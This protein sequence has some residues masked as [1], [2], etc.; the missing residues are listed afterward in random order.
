M[1][2]VYAAGLSVLYIKQCI[3]P[4]LSLNRGVNLL[5]SAVNLAHLCKVTSVLMSS[6]V[7]QTTFSYD[8]VVLCIGCTVSMSFSK[9][10]AL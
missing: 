2:P 3:C 6:V 10:S 1:L 5:N 4:A 7:L 8:D 9:V